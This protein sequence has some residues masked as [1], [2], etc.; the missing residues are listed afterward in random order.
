MPDTK[1]A[2]WC[3]LINTGLYNIDLDVGNTDL[4]DAHLGRKYFSHREF[5]NEVLTA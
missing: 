1:Y 4:A 3:S 5:S 2:S